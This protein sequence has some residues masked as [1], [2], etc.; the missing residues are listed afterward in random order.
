[1]GEETVLL[2]PYT[3]VQMDIEKLSE[4]RERLENVC[5]SKNSYKNKVLNNMIN[6]IDK[7][8]V[9]KRKIRKIDDKYEWW[10]ATHVK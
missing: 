2:T 4:I 10:Q 5:C 3:I 1:M 9:L 8:I 6:E 7:E